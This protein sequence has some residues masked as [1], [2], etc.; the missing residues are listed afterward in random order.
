MNAASARLRDVARSPEATGFAQDPL[1]KI[2]FNLLIPLQVLLVEAN[3]TRAAERTGVTQPAMSGSLARLR[4]HF[5]DPLLTRDGRGMKLTPFGAAL[6]EPVNHA[7][8]ALRSALGGRRTSMPRPA[9]RTFTIATSDYV[10]I[11]LVKPL[12]QALRAAA[13]DVSLKIVPTGEDIL[14]PL[15]GDT[16]DLLIAPRSLVPQG[17]VNHHS[18]H[19]C[20]DTFVAVAD[21]GNATLG[22]S[23]RH[24][25]EVP[26]I[27]AGCYT[28]GS[29]V[30]RMCLVADTPM[31]TL[32]P[33][34][35]YELLGRKIGLRAIPLETEV[36]LHE[37]MYWHP[38]HNADPD[39]IWLRDKLSDVAR[40]LR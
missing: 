9:G 26:G 1:S 33:A 38:R 37:T 21:A 15:D 4:R 16:C 5:G 17:K 39:H 20:T 18:R 40:S 11:I 25:R 31:I 29:F 34:R 14:S 24:N 7:V 32:V 23:I 22:E 36:S 28:A 13:P 12:L 2:D 8:D 27:E 6:V 30:A 10:S 3:V 19:L 35:L